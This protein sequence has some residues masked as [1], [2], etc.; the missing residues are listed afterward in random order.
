MFFLNFILKKYL[1]KIEKTRKFRNFF[2]DDF[3]GSALCYDPGHFGTIILRLKPHK[4]SDQYLLE[5]VVAVKEVSLIWTF[6]EGVF[7]YTDRANIQ[8]TFLSWQTLRHHLELNSNLKQ[9][10]LRPHLRY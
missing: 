1:E 9:S 3:V 10:L 2:C 4:T 7:R 8:Q 6:Y 5:G